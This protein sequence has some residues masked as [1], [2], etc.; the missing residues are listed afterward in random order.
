MWISASW[1]ILCCIFSI[2]S[3]VY[4]TWQASSLHPIKKLHYSLNHYFPHMLLWFKEFVTAAGIDAS[5][6]N[7]DPMCHWSL[8]LRVEHVTLS[9]CESLWQSGYSTIYC[10]LRYTGCTVFYQNAE[11]SFLVFW[12][13]AGSAGDWF[14]DGEEGDGAQTRNHSAE[15]EFLYLFFSDWPNKNCL[16]LWDEMLEQWMQKTERKGCKKV[17]IFGVTGPFSASASEELLLRFC[18]CADRLLLFT[19]TH[20]HTHLTLPWIWE[21]LHACLSLIYLCDRKG[22]RP[23]GWFEAIYWL[24]LAG[25][26]PSGSMNQTGC[27]RAHISPPGSQSATWPSASVVTGGG[28]RPGQLGSVWLIPSNKVQAL[29]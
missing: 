22:L 8:C 28:I 6:C 12:L 24:A 20:T 13:S 15:G 10:V 29:I 2:W 9:L 16:V 25:W 14:S 5:L 21:P 26:T 17:Q 23:S 19:F 4:C 11:H 1:L 7:T 3:W 18:Q 27:E